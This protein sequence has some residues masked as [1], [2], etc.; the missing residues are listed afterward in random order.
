MCGIIYD[1]IN[2]GV[3]R[4]FQLWLSS[5]IVGDTEKLV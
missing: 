4:A 1:P 2:H 3:S 5:E